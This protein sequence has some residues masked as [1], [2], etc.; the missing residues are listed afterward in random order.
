M[1]FIMLK[2][3]NILNQAQFFKRFICDIIWLSYGNELTEKI[4]KALTNT[5]IEYEL[6]LTFRKVSTNETGKSVELLDVLYMVD[7]YNKFK[8]FTTSFIK[9]TATKRLLL[10][11]NSYHYLC[12]FKSIVFVESIRLR[13]LNETN[14]LYLKDLERLKKKCIDSY[15]NKKGVEKIINLAKT[16]F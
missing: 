13:R 12:I 7:N 8:F 15:F 11:G 2:I 14:E 4:K 3:S 6:K 9:E 10:S 5:C 1:H 16:L